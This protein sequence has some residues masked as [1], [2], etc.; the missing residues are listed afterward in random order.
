MQTPLCK[1]RCILQMGKPRPREC[2][3]IDLLKS[4]QSLVLLRVDSGGFLLFSLYLRRVRKEGKSSEDLLNTFC[5]TVPWVLSGRLESHVWMREAMTSYLK[6]HPCTLPRFVPWTL[7][8][9]QLNVK[10]RHRPTIWRPIRGE[11]PFQVGELTKVGHLLSCLAPCFIYGLAVWLWLI[12]GFSGRR[13][14][15]RSHGV[16]V[17][18]AGNPRPSSLISGFIF[19]LTLQSCSTQR[20]MS[21]LSGLFR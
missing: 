11:G 13:L 20:E 17:E 16:K 10:I 19:T 8:H 21:L 5:K 14:S 7:C 18:E 15:S 12:R 4:T 1:N 3:Q 2:L 6:I 9:F